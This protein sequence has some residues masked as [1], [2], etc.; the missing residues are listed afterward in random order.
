MH[1]IK[2]ISFP[3][4][5]EE[6]LEFGNTLKQCK[7]IGKTD[8][9]TGYGNISF[10]DRQSGDFFISASKSGIDD[11]YVSSH[12]SRIV[13]WDAETNFVES[14]GRMPASSETLSHLAVYEAVKKANYVVHVHSEIYWNKYLHHELTSNLEIE[15]GTKEMYFEVKRLLEGN[16]D[17]GTLIM[18][19]HMDGILFWAEKISSLKKTISRKMFKI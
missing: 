2:E 19:G 3:Q 10:R 17:A 14:E 11:T 5:I 1:H 13:T 18:G 16:V 15:Y 7:L 12:F 6:L 9:L 4:E 8:E